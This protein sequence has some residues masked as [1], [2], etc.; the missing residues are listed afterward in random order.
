[1]NLGLK[2]SITD[3]NTNLSRIFP[4]KSSPYSSTERSSKHYD[5][6]WINTWP[7][8]QVVQCCLP[9]I[10]YIGYVCTWAHVLY[11]HSYLAF[12][13]TQILIHIH[14]SVNITTFELCHS[15]RTRVIQ[16]INI[17]CISSIKQQK[18]SIDLMNV[19]HTWA[20][21]LRPCWEG[22]PSLSPY[23][24]DQELMVRIWT[25]VTCLRNYTNMREF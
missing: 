2:S 23:L 14:K 24:K 7:W 12:L 19:I 8:V 1:M 17:L 21:I 16:R 18:A 9:G 11:G 5:P 3:I 6:S 13:Q 22:K 10:N 15:H 20:S 25:E 4:H